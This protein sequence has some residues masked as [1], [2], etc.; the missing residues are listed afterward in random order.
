MKATHVEASHAEA[1]HVKA[2]HVGASHAEATHVG[3]SHAEASHVEASQMRLVMW[4]QAMPAYA[5][6]TICTP[7]GN[8]L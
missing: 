1:T 3:A 5:V 2:T 4:V 7:M 8:N 6:L